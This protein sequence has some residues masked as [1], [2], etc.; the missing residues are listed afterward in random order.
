M[1]MWLTKKERRIFN[2]KGTHIL[3]CPD[4]GFADK[5]VA[6]HNAEEE[7]HA[8]ECACLLNMNERIKV[9]L[10]PPD[11]IAYTVTNSTRNTAVLEGGCQSQPTEKADVPGPNRRPPKK[12]ATRKKRGKKQ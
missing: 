2:D 5:I 9:D 10:G 11:P 4:K 6:A 12:K 1:A 8:K 3:D 7:I